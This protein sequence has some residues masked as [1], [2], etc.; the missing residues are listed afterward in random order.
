[1]YKSLRLLS[2]LCIFLAPAFSFST[3]PQPASAPASMPLTFEINRGQAAPQ[4]R[5]LARSREGVLFF[6]SN[7]VT[8]A[9]PHR[10]SFRLL[11]DGTA[12][13][14]HN[15]II[16]E[17]QLIARSNYLSREPAVV[18]VE[19]F[20]ALRYPAVYPGIDVRFYG[21][22]QHLEH[23]L[24]L[25]PGADP[26]RIV[27]RAEGLDSIRVLSKG[28]V[29]LSLGRMKLTESTP[30]AWQTIHG[31]RMPVQA[32]WK[33]LSS[34]RLG[35][36]VGKYDHSQP[37][38]IDPVLT[39]AT[40]LG[41]TTGDDITTGTT[42]A[43][44]TFISAIALDGSGNIYV[45]GITTAAD[46]PT[47]AGAFDR[48]AN[49]V[50]V[51]HEDTTSQSGFVS[52]FDKTGRIL[53]YSTFLRVQIDAMA[54]DSAGHVY[55]AEAQFNED[56]GP[57]QGFDEGIHVDKL[58][59]DGSTLLFTRLF[60]QTPNSTQACI[61]EGSSFVGG[62]AAD[63]FGHVWL[64]GATDNPCL[65][66]TPGAFQTKLP[67]TNETAFVAK[68]DTTQ[69]PD[70]SL[71]YSTYLGGNNTDTA[72][73]LTVDGSGQAYVAGR[74]NSTNFPH[75]QA[76]GTDTASVGFISKLNA[77]GSGLVFSTLLRGVTQQFSGLA[78]DSSR[79]VYAAGI[80]SS[81]GFP[82]TSAA[83]DRT[84]AGV[85]AF[86]TKLNSSGSA[87]AYSTFLGGSG[88]ET[89]LGIR[90]NSAGIAFVTGTTSSTDFPTTA[91]AFKRTLPAGAA[92]AFVTALQPSGSS[93][94]YST[95]LGGSTNTSG[96]AIFVDPSWNAF[97]GGNTHDMDF[98]VTANAFQ[99]SLKGDSDGFFAKIVIAA[100]LKAS[101][102]ENVTSV[103]RNGVVTYPA[104]VTN[105]GPD[106]SDAVVLTDAIPAGFSFVGIA[107]STASSCSA[108]AAGATSGSVIC[109]KTRLEK[110]QTYGVT[111]YLRAI[112]AS[113]SNLTNRI[114]ASART[115]DLHPANNTAAVTV[116]VN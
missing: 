114:K 113:G 76:F 71:V 68:F 55:S 63:N 12:A 73:A 17:E 49:S 105:L 86:I 27:L 13:L 14:A 81:G 39:Y 16:P 97:V 18:N 67:N 46:F 9:V 21:R 15:A 116:H 88:N 54:V 74:T 53:I 70:S 47:T 94:Y 51:F 59:A 33:L 20:A 92:N 65:P 80:T 89:A 41:G 8:V 23:D 57:N 96:E 110:G 64:A 28:D 30:V 93:L 1:M 37:L 98:P 11:F 72:Q 66:T 108:P 24:L 29:E 7:G 42:F 82:T 3:Q 109:R 85:D 2:A 58:S 6:T 83:F 111:I 90:V 60:A 43:A 10:G 106:G 91:N 101:L 78:L 38:T 104:K 48:T 4:V 31:K 61:T 45:G 22:E 35:I 36:A 32:Q 34:N 95:L 103:S 100:D 84:V 87:L 115:Q 44:D 52:K 56:R 102:T 107:N 79:N 69:A 40:H 26:G 62:L 77:S 75:G 25:H 19:N 5:F 112:A 50:A 99:P